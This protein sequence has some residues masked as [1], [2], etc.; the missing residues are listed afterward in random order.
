M[1]GSRLKLNVLASVVAL[2]ASTAVT[3]AELSVV[4]LTEAQ[5][6][7]VPSEDAD[8][9]AN[10]YEQLN[11]EQ[12]FGDVQIGG[13]V[14]VYRASVDGRSVTYLSQRF[15]RW[16][17]G[18]IYLVAGNYYGI[19]GRG[20]TFRAFDA[21]GVILESS[22]FRQRYNPT[23]DVEGAMGSWTADRIEAKALVGRPIRGA[24]PPGSPG[25]LSLGQKLLGV[26]RDRR[27]DWVAGGEASILPLEWLKIGGTAMHLRPSGVE[28]RWAWSG[29][30][31][32]DL[33]QGIRA[34]GLTDGYG[35]VYGEFARRAGGDQKGHARYLSWQFGFGP[36]GVSAEFKDYDNFAL[37][38]NDPPQLVREHTAY[39]LNRR[40]HVLQPLEE[41]G[42][43]VEAF[44]APPGWA[45]LT[46]NVSAA[47]NRLSSAVTTDYN[48][49]Y[50]EVDIQRLPADYS[51][52]IYFDWG[53]DELRGRAAMRTAGLL[54]GTT[55]LRGHAVE[56][57]VQIQRGKL[58]FGASP[59]YWDTY[60]TLSWHGPFGLGAAIVIDR[61]TDPSETDLA[62][63]LTVFETDP[64]TLWS[65]NLSGRLG[66]YEAVIFAGERR[67]GT[68][69]T[70]GTCYQVLSFRGVEMRLTTRL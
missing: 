25:T 41:E 45:T 34:T 52:S 1:I 53:K 7:K 60:G 69:C 26:G 46:V 62:E 49:R 4:S 44:Y 2:G 54:V 29:L 11:V 9:I 57:D 8:A 33:T 27:R 21:P 43:Q 64:L 42:Y 67:G 50:V 30:A 22:A 31:G 38:A 28:S 24:I 47:R 12:S 70:S 23:E 13:R 19:L 16:T 63:T 17:N 59:W 68:S 35:S 36:V 66:P 15:L 18:P 20:L 3:P 37:I 32:I 10:V 65:L 14:E 55:A 51:A 61:T 5:V 58:A 6:G 39:L 48:E 40:T 56:L